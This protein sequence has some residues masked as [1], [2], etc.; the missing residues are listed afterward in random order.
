MKDKK[1]LDDLIVI[2]NPCKLNGDE[3]KDPRRLVWKL[4]GKVIL[5]NPS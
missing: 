3:I 5:K 4:D 2:A 1:I